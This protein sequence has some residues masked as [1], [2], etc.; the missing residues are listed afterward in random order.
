MIES[1]PF[2]TRA[3]TLDHLGREQIADVPTAISE[4]WK[5]AYDAYASKVSLVAFDN[6]PT[7]ITI[8]DDG[9]GMSKEDLTDKWLVVG[10]ESKLSVNQED[11]P[12][13]FGL[14]FRPKQ[15]QK[16]IGRLSAGHL[17]ALLLLVSKKADSDKFGALLIDW[18]IFEN[19]YLFLS[20]INI[21]VSEA[22]SITQVFDELPGLFAT[23]LENIK[24]ELNEEAEDFDENSSKVLRARRVNEAWRLYDEHALAGEFGEPPETA[25]SADIFK[26]AHTQNFEMGLINDWPVFNG[27][28]NHGTALI[29]SAVNEEINSLFASGRDPAKELFIQTL[30][31][32]VD[33]FVDPVNSTE[34][35]SNIPD[36]NY[37]AEARAGS[38]SKILLSS[39][40]DVSYEVISAMEHF[41][42]GTFD[43]KGVF[44]GRV[45]AFGQWMGEHGHYVVMPPG[46]LKSSRLANAQLGPV[47]L[48]VATHEQIEANSTHTRED[49]Q[50]FSQ[51]ERYTGLRVY[52]NSLR[53]MPYGRADN[54]FFEIEKRRSLHAGRNYWNARRM[55]GRVGISRQNNPMLKDKAG[56]EGFIVNPAARKLKALVSHVL[57][58]V[59]QDYLGTASEL[60]QSELGRIQKINRE[61][62]AKE[63]SAKLRRRQ[64]TE[65]SKNLKA[66]NSSLPNK[67]EAL[68]SRADQLSVESSKDITSAQEV[69]EDMRVLLAESKVP[70]AP[71]KL[72]SLEGA[73]IEYRNTV[74]QLRSLVD[75]FSTNLSAKIVE[76][77]PQEPWE[78]AEKQLQRHAGQIHSRV[79][80]WSREIKDLQGHE[81]SRIQEMVSERNKLLHQMGQ[82][83]VDRVRAGQLSLSEASTSLSRL[84]E[85]LDAE[86]EDIFENYIFALESLRDSIDLQTI[87]VMGEQENAELRAELDRLNGLAQLGIAVEILGHELQSYDNMIGR[88]LEA[89]PEEYREGERSGQLIRTGYE[90]LTQQLRFLS[91]L[92]LSGTRTQRSLSGKEIFDYLS[93]FFDRALERER[94]SLVATKEFEVF[95]VFGQPARLLPVFVNLVNNSLYWVANSDHPE[96]EIQL[97]IVDE[98]VVVSDTGPGV[99]ELDVKKLFTLF[100]TRKST[101]GRGI[102]L[103]L[104]RANLAAGFHEISYGT[105]GKVRVLPGANF[106]INFKNAEF[107]KE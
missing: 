60:R 101:G 73:Y 106:V 92:Q 49:F 4:L 61:Q 30:S 48:C 52:R 98:Q 43:S 36:I 59:A 38:E 22:D 9:H 17:G 11:N 8:F 3:R 63:E 37:S 80:R 89:L 103:Y 7:I 66:T 107:P 93:K 28:N 96:K 1:R 21:P 75:D 102:G 86:N 13:M 99:D 14:N 47:D 72:G 39:N 19:P 70:G 79:N 94:I 76:I 31:G 95:S 105:D 74:S 15:G 65:F 44:R 100:F 81:I 91:P 54:D 24:V 23:L 5:N 10:T 67:I 29:I 62:K 55:Y 18:R 42:E 57:T 87:A 69:L 16:G 104:C 58:K 78:I 84:W 25:P 34:V 2:V 56:R 41:I 68:R 85:N 64:R 33:P 50:F 20:D 32:F 97:S 46:D 88:G 71:T 27:E 77:A 12:P 35:N 90:G 53:V 6:K 83:I 51:L 26:S 82:P 45:R 40:E